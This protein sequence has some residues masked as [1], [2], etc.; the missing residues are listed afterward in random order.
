L[1][2]LAFREEF[3]LF[4]HLSFK[5]KIFKEADLF[6]AIRDFFSDNHVVLLP[7]DLDDVSFNKILDAVP[8]MNRLLETHKIPKE[9][10]PVYKEIILHSLADL[11][12]LT[13]ELTQGKI[14]FSDPLGKMLDD[15]DD[16]DQD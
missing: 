1:F 8:G 4:F 6:G 5:I 15:L 11:D 13:K 7:N 10:Y 16:D 2:S 12:V 14:G 3:L 9:E